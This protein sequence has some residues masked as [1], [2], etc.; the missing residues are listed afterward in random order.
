M[1]KRGWRWMAMVLLVAGLLL[2]VG[3]GGD[4]EG[5]GGGAATTSTGDPA[6]D[7]LVTAAKEE[8]QVTF[9]A[10]PD[11]RV[12]QQLADAFE[13]KYGIEAKFTRATAAELEQR[14]SA[15]AEA[16]APVA[17]VMLTLNDGFLADAI[18]KGWMTPLDRAGI[19]G[20]PGDWIAP[21]AILRD[22][23]T[24]MVQVTNM[25]IG[26]NT[27]AAG[28]AAP[29]SWEDV[30]DPK[31]KGKVAIADPNNAIHNDL[32]YVLSK[33]YGMDYLSRLK[34]QIGRIY[35]GGAPM[36]E[37]LASGEASVAIGIVAAGLKIVKEQGAPIGWSIPKDTLASP[38]VLGVS[39]NA[40]HPNAAKL[41]AHYILSQEGL[42]LLNDSPGSIPPT[43]A[44][45]LPG[46]FAS[47]ALDAEARDHQ[48]EIFGALGAKAK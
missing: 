34:G 5:S 1:S 19:L 6:L 37:A 14:F 9:Y 22:P 16:G 28:D 29:K 10:V 40:P 21:Q 12:A 2:A 39:A 27:D 4:D 32:F 36:V 48:A 38:T 45:S 13:K 47:P 15:E 23:S 31:W 43:D 25:G 11:E 26:F 20:F 35:P 3:C 18:K 30:L 46:S 33:Q 44:A 7:K 24:V 42:K 17:D 41:L 8:G